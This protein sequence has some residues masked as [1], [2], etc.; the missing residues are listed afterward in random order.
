MVRERYRRQVQ[1][2]VQTR[3]SIMEEGASFALKGGTVINLFHRDLP[4]FSV[5]IDLVY[6]PI[7]PRVRRSLTSKAPSGA[8]ALGATDSALAW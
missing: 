2:L 7:E 3:P 5:D 6:L 4:R 1:L 8:S